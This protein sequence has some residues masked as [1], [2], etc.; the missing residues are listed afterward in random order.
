MREFLFIFVGGGIGALLR[1][2]V[3]SVVGSLTVF[4]SYG[5]TLLVN[6]VGCFVIGSVFARYERDLISKDLFLFLT[7]GILG[8]FT[9]YSA[10]GLEGFQMMKDGS[11][12][13]LLSYVLL[14]VIGGVVFVA[15]GYKLL[16]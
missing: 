10:F 9:T 6:I 16:A 12:L 8:G 1:F 11:Y 15:L 2:V 5:G 3:K 14:H 13:L 7:T 4:H